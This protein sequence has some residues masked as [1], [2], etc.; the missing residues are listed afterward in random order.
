MDHSHVLRFAR[1]VID[2]VTNAKSWKLVP[3]ELT[4]AMLDAM[5]VAGLA[6][7]DADLEASLR[8]I[9]LDPTR[10]RR[11]VWK[12]ALGTAPEVSSAEPLY[13]LRPEGVRI[14]GEP[15]AWR[16][17]GRFGWTY[18][19]EPPYETQRGRVAEPLYPQPAIDASKAAPK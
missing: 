1:A 7:F 8:D 10:G 6:A 13:T 15:V 9:A 4:D 19:E 2:K 12:A 17:W 5:Q 16:V 3:V 11:A 18:Q 14:T